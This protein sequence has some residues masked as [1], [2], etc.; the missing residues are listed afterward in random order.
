V[1]SQILIDNIVFRSVS[2]WLGSTA[3]P[4]ALERSDSVRIITSSRLRRNSYF[5]TLLLSRRALHK[6]I[7]LE[8]GMS[9]CDIYYAIKH[10]LIYNSKKIRGNQDKL[11]VSQPGCPIKVE[12]KRK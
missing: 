6:S 12:R 8:G 11:N 10:L 2:H 5:Q 3:K 7:Q 1:L 9:E 4:A